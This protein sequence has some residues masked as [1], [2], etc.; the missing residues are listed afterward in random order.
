MVAAA[1]VCG[2]VAAT[3]AAVVAVVVF[4]D[5]ETGSFAVDVAATLTPGVEAGATDL[6]AQAAKRASTATAAVATRFTRPSRRR[7]MPEEQ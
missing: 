2:V 5:V 7:S 3:V 6:S 1:A 4:G